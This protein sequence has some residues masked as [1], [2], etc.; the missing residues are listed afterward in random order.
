MSVNESS[1]LME[2]SLASAGLTNSASNSPQT[3]RH[4]LAAATDLLQTSSSTPRLD[5]EILLAHV[6][7]WQRAHL[8]AEYDFVPSEAQG[9]AFR[10]LLA[11]RAKQEP[12]AYLVGQREFYGINLLVDK[13][14]LIPRPETELVVEQALA[15]A[16][17]IKPQQPSFTI[18]DVGTGSGALA[19]AL[20][21][22]LP[23]ARL[24]ATDISADALYVAAVN[25]T[26]CGLAHQITLLHSNLLSALPRS[27]DLIVSNPPYMIL[28]EVSAPVALYEPRLALDGGPD[29]LQIYQRLFAQAGAWL[30]PQGRLVLEIGATQAQAVIDLARA[31]FPKAKLNVY[32]DLAQQDRVVTVQT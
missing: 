5:A 11:R 6:L 13:R 24:Y 30:R 27:L 20:A 3:V 17:A 29:G 10:K 19:I 14:V 28:R 4:L 31:F 26:R 7:H 15:L 25:V 9:L 32:P 8:L 23:A 2:L 22:H 12:V 1:L 18:A 21:K 16:L